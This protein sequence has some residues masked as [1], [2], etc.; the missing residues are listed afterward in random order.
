M[1][2]LRELLWAALDFGV[3][4]SSGVKSHDG[5]AVHQ[6]VETLL[7]FL[8]T[9]AVSGTTPAWISLWVCLSKKVP[10]SKVSEPKT[11]P[12]GAAPSFTGLFVHICV[13]QSVTYFA[14]KLNSSI[15]FLLCFLL[16]HVICMQIKLPRLALQ[17]AHPEGKHGIFI[18]LQNTLFPF[19][20]FCAN[21]AEFS[22]STIWSILAK[23]T[24][25]D[26]CV[27]TNG[28]LHLFPLTALWF[29]YYVLLVFPQ[30]S[31]CLI[32]TVHS[33]HWFCDATIGL[34]PINSS[35]EGIN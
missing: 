5:V 33:Q 8:S 34:S 2:F 27:Q 11:T 6:S 29:K 17:S 35:Q 3:W 10:L 20:L 23:L 12:D 4:P 14:N 7:G 24:M 32:C 1:W 21:K 30:L 19:F 15:S 25:K 26:Y 13:F 31:Q 16:L 22:L 18:Y 9:R 28:V